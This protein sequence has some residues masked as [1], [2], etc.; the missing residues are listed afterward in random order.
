[1][2]SFLRLYSFI[3]PCHAP[4]GILVPQPGI[5]P[6][7]PALES[8]VLTTGPSGEPQL[9]FWGLG[10]KSQKS[11]PWKFISFSVTCFFSFIVFAQLGIIVF[12]LLTA[13]KR[14][15]TV[16]CVLENLKLYSELYESPLGILSMRVTWFNLYFNIPH[17]WSMHYC[18]LEP[19]VFQVYI[20]R[21]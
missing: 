6:T 16:C 11:L 5:E 9:C 10:L 3:W 17:W 4:C 8:E 13:C 12:K 19:T 18:M 7:P 2:S 15:S 1:M 20:D 21:C 14:T